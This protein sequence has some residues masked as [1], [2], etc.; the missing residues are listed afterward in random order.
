MLLRSHMLS[1]RAQELEPRL[2]ICV[3]ERDPVR[4]LLDVR[5]GVQVV[6]FDV[7]DVE[8]FRDRFSERAFT[9]AGDALRW[10]WSCDRC[11]AR[12]A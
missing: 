1:G 12:Y 8:P 2:A 7:W 9:R 5:L 11:W 6:A 4:H 3:R 10:R